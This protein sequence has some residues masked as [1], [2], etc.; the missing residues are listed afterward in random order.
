MQARSQIPPLFSNVP[1]KDYLGI[2][3][4]GVAESSK[5]VV[6][7]L[8][9]TKDDV[10]S[11]TEVAKSSIRY[12]ERMPEELAKRLQEI[13]VICELVAEYFNGDVEKTA[14]WFKIKNP[15]LGGMSPRDM[16]RLGRYQKLIKL[17]QNAL[18]GNTP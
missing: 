16:I 7:F 8:D 6:K 14:L 18:V 13:A 15:M 4:G 2:I 17:I 1:K 11:A 10:A 3:R 9:F 5:K 12:D